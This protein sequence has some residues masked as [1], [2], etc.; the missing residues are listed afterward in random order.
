MAKLVS[1]AGDGMG[2]LGAGPACALLAATALQ[3]AANPSSAAQ[4][5]QYTYDALGRVI[6]AIDGNGKKVVYSYDSAGNRTRV[7]NGAEFQEINPTAWSASSNGGTTGLATANALKDGDFNG[8]ASIHATQT[9]TNAWIM[10]DLGSAQAVNH[11]DVAPA[12][13]TATGAGPE[14]LNGT[15]VE[16]SVAGA[17]WTAAATINGASPGAARSVA[18]G[19]VT[20]RYVR[21]RRAVSGQVAVGDL[22]LFSAAAANSP[23]IAQPDSIASAG[24]AVTFDPRTNDQDLDGYTFSISAVEDPPHGTAV[25]NSGTSVTYTPDPGY[26]GADNFL[27][28][29]A[30]GHNGTASARVSVLVR[31]NTN[32]PPAAVY[33]Y[34]T[35]SDRVTALVDGVNSLRPTSNDWD[36]D[37]DVL[38]I[39][40]K[41]NP[42][43][44][45]AT[46]V[47]ANVIEYQPA[48]GYTGS[49][50]FT[51]T[52]SD[53]R[54]G[55]G[56][57]TI[58][59]TLANT[60]PVAA[61]DNIAAT[62]TTPVTFDPRLNDRDP[63]GDP[64]TVGTL[65]AP[66]KGAAVLNGDQTITYTA[67]SGATGTDTFTYTLSDGRGGTATGSVTVSVTPNSPPV[68]RNDALSASG[69][70]VS[71]DPRTNDTDADNDPISLVSVTQ[72]AHGAVS[73]INNGT[74]VTYT[75]T[76][77]YTGDDNFTYT[78]ADD[79]G[80]QATAMVMVN[81]LSIEYLVVAGGGGG[82][83]GPGGGGGGGGLLSGAAPL[84]QGVARTITVGAGG[85]GGDGSQTSG[86]AG[87]ASTFNGLTAVGGGG[88]GSLTT[89]ATSGG[90]GGGPA[91]AGTS[92]QGFAGGA[93]GGGGKGGGGGAGGVGGTSVNGDGGAGGAGIDSSI[94]GAAVNYAAGGGGAS[95]APA[96]GSSATAGQAMGNPAP[97]PAN[98]GG[99]GGGGGRVYVDGLWNVSNGG[100]GGSGVVI[101]RY[102]GG[103]KA[104]GGT[105][106]QSGGYT[107]H[108][109]TAGGTFTVTSANGAPVAVNDSLTAV[110]GAGRAFDPR[111]NDSDPNGDAL[112]VVSVG[113]AAHGTVRLSPVGHPILYTPTAGYTG[114]D[115]FTYTVSDGAAGATA[116][117]NVTVSAG[118]SLEYLVVAGGGGGGRGYPGRGGGGGGGGVR[119]GSVWLPSGSYPVTIGAG[120]AGG[121]GSTAAA[122]G[123]TSDLAGL[124]AVGGGAGATDGL[125]G[126]AG[127][128][129]G[130]A[131]GSN[132]NPMYNTLTG[133]GAGQA[134]QG[135]SGGAVRYSTGTGG[136]GGAGGPGGG[137]AGDNRSGMGGPGLSSAISGAAA[138]YGSGGGGSGWGGYNNA[139]IAY[140]AAGG[141]NAGSGDVGDGGSAV[142]NRGGGGGGGGMP[143]NPSRSYNGGAGG[144]GIV[145]VRYP[146]GSLAASGGTVT[147]SGGYTIHTFTS[148][149]TLVIP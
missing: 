66:S 125:A 69:V 5:T 82:G 29:V 26:F 88:G 116:T 89:A 7:S 17:T 100:N 112:A 110:S 117:V 6:S 80:A 63:N 56:T 86:A 12:V 107:V 58:S 103:P 120:G 68:A 131:S 75:P 146:T 41:T 38:T 72:P 139:V 136:G 142:A 21:I 36:A 137:A 96:G 85:A 91:A 144:S 70:A 76:S 114:A 11:I 99:G 48:V 51:Y 14:D 46:L 111:G 109:F 119:S 113:A 81:S 52:I 74:A 19:G 47:G 44:G 33:D 55:S 59:L 39:T 32:H 18:L 138:V 92:G 54:G 141:E 1:A 13:A 106:T 122:N 67:N 133:G 90:S 62:K 3:F 37:G 128:S 101:L 104:T 2:R 16:Y 50:S 79:E 27:Y 83:S 43:H 77:G 8:L 145:I 35:V 94:S 130:G 40:A 135:N 9:E 15:V 78:V 22:R 148:G 4:S 140:A 129:G 23:L 49:D 53:G 34:L 102:A 115:S 87:G 65:G 57:A 64:L 147:T 98:R 20:A 93:D 123:G 30:D 24:A 71:L 60:N 105:I 124:V 108:T 121:T 118:T 42:A 127:G 97:A 95:I 61:A 28:T 126:S 10:A 45:T 132:S 134:G 84:S 25:V 31:P 149:G 73:V 143:Y